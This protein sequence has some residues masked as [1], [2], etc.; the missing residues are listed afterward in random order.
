MFVGN[1]SVLLVKVKD[2]NGVTT[3]VFN[4][5]CVKRKVQ[6]RTRQHGR[7][8]WLA[9][10]VLQAYQFPHTF[11]RGATRAAVCAS[12]GR[13]AHIALSPYIFQGCNTVGRVG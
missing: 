4:R 7:P 3:K 13:V 9:R 8:C 5:G 10:A 6:N 11:S 12:T 1:H 2:S